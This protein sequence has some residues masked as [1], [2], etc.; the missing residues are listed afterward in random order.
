MLWASATHGYMSSK[1]FPK[2][3]KHSGRV[4]YFG[5]PYAPGRVDDRYPTLMKAIGMR[6]DDCI[7]FSILLTESLKKYGERLAAQYGRGAPKIA[8]PGFDKAGDLLPDMKYY[9]DG[10]SS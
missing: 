6:T 10:T 3:M 4:L 2:R 1:T 9:S 7:A 5:E 8:R